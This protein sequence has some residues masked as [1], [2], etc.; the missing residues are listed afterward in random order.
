MNL[1]TKQRQTHRQRTQLWLPRGGSGGG[2]DWEWG[3]NRYRMDKLIYRMD[4]QQGP[5]V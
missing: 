3:I 5:T 4:Q 1:S 2:M